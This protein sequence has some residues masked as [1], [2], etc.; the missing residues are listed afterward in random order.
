[1]ENQKPL[2]AESDMIDLR[3]IFAFGGLSLVSYGAFLIF[4]PV[5]F[6]T[7][8]AGLWWLG[9]RRIVIDQPTRK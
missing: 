5:A 8:G 3:D 4:Q 9:V 2:P 7:F 1:M 6:I